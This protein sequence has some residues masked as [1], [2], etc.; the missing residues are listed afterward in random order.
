MTT[1]VRYSPEDRVLNLANLSQADFELIRSL[2][3]QIYRG[4]RTLLSLQSTTEGNDELHIRHR[5]N[6]YWAAHFPGGGHGGH[7][8]SVETPEHRRQKE[9]WSRAGQEAGFESAFEV[10]TGNGTILDV[11]IKGPQR[12][13]VEVQRSGITRTLAKT[14][15]TKSLNAGWLPLWFADSDRTPPWFHKIPSVGCNKIS[16][17][18]LP[19][20]RAATATG[21]RKLEAV[22]CVVGAFDTCPDRRKRPCG[23]F[24]PKPTPWG[25]LTVDDVAAMVPAK[26]IVPLQVR[27]D[28]IFLVPH[29]ALDFFRELTG[30]DG[31]YDPSRPDNSDSPGRQLQQECQN[32]AHDTPRY[33]LECGQLLLFNRPGRKYCQGCRDLPMTSAYPF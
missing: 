1:Y 22:R 24:H 17:D 26:E 7:E 21:L 6:K 32:P 23:R 9:Y 15:T 2:C 27:R 30:R 4:D 3:G 20:R 16:W 33:C 10:S 29:H 13:G 12:T 25:G 14:R 18:G 8:V 11:A 5:D 31:R 19:P 28:S